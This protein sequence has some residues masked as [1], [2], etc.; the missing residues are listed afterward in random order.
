MGYAASRQILGL[1]DY[2]TR[3]I[4]YLSCSGMGHGA[5]SAEIIAAACYSEIRAHGIIEL[6]WRYADWR[7][8]FRIVGKIL[9]TNTFKYRC[10]FGFE[11]PARGDTLDSFC[12]PTP[13]GGQNAGANNDFHLG[14]NRAPILYMSD[15]PVNGFLAHRTGA[16]DYDI[17]SPKISSS[18]DTRAAS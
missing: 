13:V 11:L 6:I 14:I 10:R 5:K 18:C 1:A 7:A 15:E 16:S 17:S 12:Q 3:W 4:G 2:M 8:S 9:N